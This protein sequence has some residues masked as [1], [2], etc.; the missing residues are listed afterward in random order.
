LPS[1][2][3]LEKHLF[4]E[5]EDTVKKSGSKKISERYVD[6]LFDVANAAGVLAVVEKDLH[7]LSE[8][9][10]DNADFREFLHNPLLTRQAKG[11]VSEALLEHIGSNKVTAQFI[12]LLAAHKRLDLLAEMTA[13]FLKKCSVSRGELAAELVAAQAI[14]EK[15]TSVIAETLSKA[16]SKKIKLSVRGDASLLGGVIV[17]VG[18]LRL[19]SSLSGK[20][21]RL[22]QTLKTA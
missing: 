11:S 14:S 19:D 15:E 22:K 5:V 7:T 16:Y 6:A 9:L 12:A 17:N 10:A 1:F 3:T 2:G 21:N 13:L 20:L 4:V 18:S 8:M